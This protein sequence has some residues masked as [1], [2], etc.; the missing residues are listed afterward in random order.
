MNSASRP[1]CLLAALL[2]LALVYG[3]PVAANGQAKA[4]P[5]QPAQKVAPASRA[6]FGLFARATLR[7]VGNRVSCF[8]AS[9]GTLCGPE[10]SVIGGAYWPAGTG[11]QYIFSSGL[12]FAG[13]IDPASA[14]NPWAGDVEGAFVYNARGGTNSQAITDVYDGADPADLAAWPAEAYVPS[15]TDLAAALYHP[16]IQGRKTVS[17]RDIWFLSWEGDPS[18]SGGRTH[19][20]GIMVETRGL[21][22]KTGG[23]QDLVFFLLTFYNIT[24]GNPAAYNSAPPRLQARLREV[25][26]RFQ[27]LNESQG[28]LLPEDG[29]TIQDMYFAVSTDFDITSED[30]GANFSSVN[31]PSGLGYSYHHTFHAPVSWS[32]ADGSI[33]SPPFFAAAGLVGVKFLK[34]PELNGAERGLTLFGGTTGG[35][36]FSDP[37]NTQA[38]YRYMIGQPDPTLGDDQCNTGDPAVTHICYI[39]QGSSSDTRFFQVSGPITLAPGEYQP[40][41]VAYVFAAPVATGLCTGPDLCGAIPPQRP[42]GDVTR[43]TNPAALLLGANLVDSIAGYRGWRDTT[44]TRRRPSGDSIVFPNGVIDQEELILVPGSLL[45]KARTAQAMFDSQFLLPAPPAAPEF[46]LIPGNDQVTVVWRPSATES[47]GDP[48]YAVAQAPDTYDP[49]YRQYDVAGYRIYRGMRDDPASLRLLAQFDFKGDTWQDRTGQINHVTSEGYTD[50]APPLG[51]FRGCTSGGVVNGVPTISPIEVSLDGP[52]TQWQTVVGSGAGWAFATKVDTA[53][54]GGGNSR[55]SLAGT[56]IPFVFVDRTGTCA[57]CGVRTHHRYYYLVT[58]FD[59]NSIRSGP[60]SLESSLTGTRSVVP[61]PAPVNVASTGTVLP[62]E[63]LGRHGVLTDSVLPTLDAA[64]GRFSKRFPPANGASL[65]LGAFLP[66]VLPDSGNVTVRLDS[67]TIGQ[68]GF[69]T[70]ITY[71][72]S[73]GQGPSAQRFTTMLSQSLFEVSEDSIS[74]TFDNAVVLDSMA[75]AQYGGSN[76]FALQALLGQV[77]PSV[78]Y[79]S[80]YGRGCLNLAPGF[81]YSPPQ[82]GCDYNGSRWFMGPS[83]TSNESRIHPAFGNAQNQ[84][85]G[86]VQLNHALPNNGGWNNAGELTGVQVIHQPYSYQ[87]MGDQWRRIERILGGAKRAAD[88][89]VYWNAAIPGKI[90]SVIDVTHDVTVPFD[91][92]RIGASWGVLNQQAAQPSGVGVSADQR[93]ELT[94][95]D[96]GCVEPIRNLSLDNGVPCGA[97]NTPGDGP[98]YPLDSIAR[99][100]PIAHFDSAPAMARTSP[101]TGQGFAMYL[102]GNLFMFQTGT[103][104]QGVVWSLRDY[105]GAITGGNGFGGNDGPYAFYPV[106][107]PF[108]AVGASLRLRFTA[109]TTVA[110]ARD[111]DLR[112]VH[113][114]PDPYYERSALEP[115]SAERVIKFVNLPER[116]II[117][118]YTV[119]GVLVTVL[120]H[121]SLTSS[122]ATWDLRNRNGRLVASGVYFWH[123]EALN[124]RRV[125]RMTLIT[126]HRR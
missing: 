120:E 20:L 21:V 10:S 38:L 12:Q 3:R 28:S 8:M 14:N 108:A 103:L 56:G 31:V 4:A 100:G 69:V 75:A 116:A 43:F 89:N 94:L 79:T 102:P 55:P 99:L 98:V 17:D 44:F 85:F 25:G 62:L 6:A 64:T 51:V 110:N 61:G 122:E 115:S 60:S 88:Y 77:L 52:I 126:A 125:G 97:D 81:A 73:T 35:G 7:W 70:A 92:A 50:C 78:Y 113:T 74:T 59:L 80:S 32:F 15:G 109:T 46:F 41:A 1:T 22:F 11:N 96:F 40:L 53:F 39:N 45:G 58:A 84:L 68:E 63:V 105:V 114:V 66:A 57:D 95:T 90:D 27:Q 23:A 47:E 49:N 123:V 106:V 29:Y 36:E 83:P 119:S 48:R 65:A 5:V 30:A 93:T 124:A 87:T 24:A 118:I 9:N 2:G 111:R 18:L 86:T 112:R 91:A 13:I 71:H 54:S 67:L 33:F 34:T 26:A 19:P 104:P 107:R 76:R 121:N 16:S 82:A 72:W 42:T 117:R 37:R 101:F